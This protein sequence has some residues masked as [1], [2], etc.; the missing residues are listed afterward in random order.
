[1]KLGADTTKRAIRDFLD[2]ARSCA[3]YRKEDGVNVHGYAAMLTAFSCVLSIGEMLVIDR[4]RGEYTQDDDPPW[5]RKRKYP[6][7]RISIQEF[8]KEMEK[9]VDWRF[10]LFPPE[11]QTI[12]GAGDYRDKHWKLLYDLRNALVHA[13]SINIY[14]AMVPDKEWAQSEQFRQKWRIVVPD[15]ITAVEKTCEHIVEEH[16]NVRWDPAGPTARRLATFIHT[17]DST[18]S[19]SNEETAAPVDTEGTT[20]LLEYVT[21]ISG[22]GAA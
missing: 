6:T 9:I 22:N 14:V 5:R 15:F 1:M 13:I 21:H 4:N 20:D 8:Y 3:R 11:G 17:E 16:D 7:D 18:G 19:R 10:W 12:D 2:E